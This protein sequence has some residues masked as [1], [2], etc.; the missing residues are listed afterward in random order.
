M[1]RT[2][3]MTIAAIASLLLTSMTANAEDKLTLNRTVITMDTAAKVAKATIAAC[4]KEG[5]SV[6]VTVI[7]RSGQVLAVLRDTLAMEVTLDLS[8]LKAITALSMNSITSTLAARYKSPGAL[9]KYEGLLFM[10][11]GVP[12]NAGGSILGAVGVSGSP[13]G[14]TDEKCAVKGVKAITE[15]LE[16][17]M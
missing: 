9:E 12:I 4:R 14:N 5:T 17:S 13:S 2:I 1:K 6:A 10:P 11:G 3:P 15:E 16:M 8:K 7:N